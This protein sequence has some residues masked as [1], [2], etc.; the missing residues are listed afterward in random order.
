MKDD[1]TY[2]LDFR[3]NKTS[4]FGEDGIIEK[5]LDILPK[6]AN[7]W[8]VEFGAWDGLFCSNTNSLITE[9][10]FQA[11]LIEGDEKKIPDLE[12][13]FDKFHDKVHLIHEWVDFDKNSIDEIFI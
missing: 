10:G 9:E 13:T 11:V 1:S 3:K 4:Q 7:P 6:E 2:L 8:C 5:I 12:K